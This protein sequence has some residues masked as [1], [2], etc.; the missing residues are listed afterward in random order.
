MSVFGQVTAIELV[1]WLAILDNDWFESES[2]MSDF[3]HLNHQFCALKYY[4][5]TILIKRPGK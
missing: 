3:S 5:R 4:D 2:K 1:S